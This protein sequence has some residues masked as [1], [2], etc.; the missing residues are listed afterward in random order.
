MSE[1][2]YVQYGCGL[3]APEGWWNFDSSPTLRFERLPIVGR[4]YTRNSL[5]FPDSVRYGDVVKG[6]PIPASSCAGVYCSHVLEHLSLE[7]FRKSLNNTFHM[8]KA[9]GVF[10]LVLP[11]LEREIEKY[12]GNKVATAAMDFMKETCLGRERRPRN[13]K[14]WI[15]SWLGASQ[16]LW[17][18]DYRA[19]EV[20]LKNAGFVYIRRANFDD[21]QDERFKEA[22]D[23]NRWDNCLEVEC[24][25]PV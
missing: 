10:R 14:S 9:G 4:L 23:K 13:L 22:E 11:D 20:E 2:I 24:K 17:M 19:I 21:C 12:R 7:D 8:L 5:R 18:W 15:V 1:D 3:S 6:L 25:K 16:H